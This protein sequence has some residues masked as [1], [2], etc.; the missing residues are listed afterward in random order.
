M[1]TDINV[2]HDGGGAGD[3]INMDNLVQSDLKVRDDRDED[4]EGDG[5]TA[6]GVHTQS[7]VIGGQLVTGQRAEPFL[8][9]QGLGHVG[10]GQLPALIDQVVSQAEENWA[11]TQILSDVRLDLDSANCLW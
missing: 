3:G 1:V 8:I 5:G 2:V 11:L 7:H 6:G 9:T 4:G 10:V